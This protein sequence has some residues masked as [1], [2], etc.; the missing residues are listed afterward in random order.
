MQKRTNERGAAAVELALVLPILVTLLFGIIEC[1]RYYNAK[2]TLTHAAREGAR[3][4]A[5]GGTPGDAQARVVATAGGL[6][7]VSVSAPTACPTTVSASPPDATVT[8]TVPFSFNIPFV[9]IGGTS[10][11]STAVMRCGG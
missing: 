11:S 1:G 9:P 4:L 2:V 10:I 6:S 5:L 7:G 8:A 3:T